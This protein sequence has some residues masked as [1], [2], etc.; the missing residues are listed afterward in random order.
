MTRE[1]A[2]AGGISFACL[3]VYVFSWSDGISLVDAGLFQM[4]CQDNGIA[5]PPGY[6]LATLL[7]HPFMSLSLP[8]TLPGNLFSALFAAATLVVFFSLCRT[9]S[10]EPVWSVLATFALGL[11]LSFWSQSIIIEVYTL[12]TFLFGLAYL[13]TVRYLDGHRELWL[14]VAVLAFA[15]GL[16]N[17]W[18]LIILSSIAFIPILL[19]EY[20]RVQAVLFRPGLLVTLLLCLLVG[21]SP[22][23][24]ILTKPVGVV[25]MIG[26]IHSIEDLWRLVSRQTYQD[27]N[28]E[29]I[30]QMQS[31]LW[32][33]PLMSINQLGMLAWVL[34][35]LGML[36][37]FYCLSR[38]YAVS[39]LLLWVSNVMIL[40][41]ISS[42]P[43]DESM[44]AHYVSWTLLA[45]FP[46][47]IWLALGVKFLLSRFPT[48]EGFAAAVVIL[49]IAIQN[50]SRLGSQDTI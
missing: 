35:P 3:L 22:Y 28:L 32:W 50:F 38:R 18:P 6:P 1:Q 4:V 19:A 44:Q 8:G 21:L 5:H 43:F 36:H 23:L 25:S 11:A 16:S 27:R 10:L 45:I 30:S 48:I 41:L 39:L 2:W 46:C 14:V 17:H 12:N 26:D 13:S 49:A 31:Y 33:L 29:G 42:Y 9:F 7:C 20:T 40:P 24:L 15:L 34:V 37:S 47:A